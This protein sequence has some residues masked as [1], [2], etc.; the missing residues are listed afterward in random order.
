M[1][2]AV[3]VNLNCMTSTWECELCYTRNESLLL[4]C[5]FC[6]APLPSKPHNAQKSVEKPSLPISAPQIAS[7][8]SKAFTWECRSCFILNPFKV[9]RCEICQSPRFAS[10]NSKKRNL[11]LPAES[12]PVTKKPL[13]QEIGMY[14]LRLCVYHY[15]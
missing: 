13:T 7:T 12:E 15:I 10:Q 6:E 3:S 5:S 4:F 8:P 11:P 2:S 9:D 14:F 1:P